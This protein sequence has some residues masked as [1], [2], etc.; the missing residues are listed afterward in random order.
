MM[1]Y[2]GCSI[3]PLLF[4]AAVTVVVVVV[5]GNECVPK[6]APGNQCMGKAI[7]LCDVTGLLKMS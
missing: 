4:V 7:L 5:P 1:A 6:L 3:T 2:F